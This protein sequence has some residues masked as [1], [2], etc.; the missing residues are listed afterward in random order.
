MGMDVFGKK[1]KTDV[2]GYFRNNVWWWHP[3]WDYCA[4][5]EPELCDK[6]AEAHSNS[7]DGLNAIDSRKLAFSLREQIESGATQIYKDNYYKN[8]DLLPD[9]DC[10]CV[11]AKHILVPDSENSGVCR[12]CS[13][14]LKI[15]SFLKSYHFDVENVQKFADFLMDCGGFEIC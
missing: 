5:V 13:G 2:G 10:Y 9:E 6:V 14:S 4:T 12:H 15:P 11:T 3:L 8:L 1:P 7:G